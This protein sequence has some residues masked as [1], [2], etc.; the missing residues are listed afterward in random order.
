MESR[1]LG[2]PRAFDKLQMMVRSYSPDLV[3]ISETKLCGR[4]AS[5]VKCRLGFDGGMH[6]DSVGRSGS[7]VFLWKKDWM[8]W[9]RDI[10]EALLIVL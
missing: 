8:W 4:R 2:D 6:V 9:L 3:F 7:L 5:L 1:R 10:L